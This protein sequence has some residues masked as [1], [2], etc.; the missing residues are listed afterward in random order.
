MPRRLHIELHVLAG[1]GFCAPRFATEVVL[2]DFAYLQPLLEPFKL[3]YFCLD[4]LSS[5]RVS[6]GLKPA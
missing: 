2:L 4:A 6:F 1:I 5:S 3:S